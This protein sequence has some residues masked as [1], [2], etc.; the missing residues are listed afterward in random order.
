[1]TIVKRRQNISIEDKKKIRHYYKSNNPKPTHEKIKK[2]CK[3]TSGLDIPQSTIS[4][5][6]SSQYSHLD[7][8]NTDRDKNKRLRAPKFAELECILVEVLYK[9]ENIGIPGFKMIS[10]SEIMF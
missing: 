6:L 7:D 10:E 5:I 4:S 8:S 9:Y 1:M 3:D 2:W